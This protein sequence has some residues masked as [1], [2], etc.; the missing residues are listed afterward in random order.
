[1]L[2]LIRVL[3]IHFRFFLYPFEQ[4]IA[5]TMRILIHFYI[6]VT[7]EP[8]PNVQIVCIHSRC[9][10]DGVGEMLHKREM[11]EEKRKKLSIKHMLHVGKVRKVS[12]L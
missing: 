8:K 5:E 7:N 12:I 10:L 2:D 1:M 3:I 9:Y 11:R 4:R 6:L